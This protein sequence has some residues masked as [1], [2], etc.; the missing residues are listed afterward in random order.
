MAKITL[1]EQF[2]NHLL[3][4]Y[5][6]DESLL[7]HLIEDLGDYFSKDA[8]DF[9]S[10]RHQQLHKEGLRNNEIYTRIHRELKE[11][12]FAAPELSIRQ[13]RRIIYG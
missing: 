13:I 3:S 11:R 9:I 8:K 2:K 6:I 1:D 7:N 10:L 5:P 4:S 12:R